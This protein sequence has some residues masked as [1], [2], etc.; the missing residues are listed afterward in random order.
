ME[1]LYVL[2]SQPSIDVNKGYA[3]TPLQLAV[4]EGCLEIVQLLLLH[5]TLYPNSISIAADCFRESFASMRHH[6]F[7]TEELKGLVLPPLDLALYH[8]NP[9]MFSLLVHDSRLRLTERLQ[10]Q[11]ER[12]PW[13]WDHVPFMEALA[14]LR[15]LEWEGWSWRWRR[16][17]I[18]WG[19]ITYVVLSLCNL[20]LWIFF[21]KDVLDNSL[22]RI[23]VVMYAVS[24]IVGIVG[25]LLQR[26]KTVHFLPQDASHHN[27]NN[28][29]TID[30]RVNV[31]H[32][33]A[34]YLCYSDDNPRSNVSKSLVFFTFAIP[35][36]LPVAE[37]IMF[38]YNSC[39]GQKRDIIEDDEER[40]EIMRKLIGRINTDWR[41]K[42]F[43]KGE[44][45]FPVGPQREVSLESSPVPTDMSSC[46][47]EPLP[48]APLT[49]ENIQQLKR[50]MQEQEELA[51]VS[52]LNNNTGGGDDRV[53]DTDDVNSLS[54]RIERSAIPYRTAHSTDS[55]NNKTG[56]SFHPSKRQE[57]SDEDGVRVSS[58]DA[59]RGRRLS[60][61]LLSNIRAFLAHPEADQYLD[62]VGEIT[63]ESFSRPLPA[64]GAAR[65]LRRLMD[66]VEEGDTVGMHI[67]A[68]RTALASH[69][70]RRCAST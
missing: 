14:V 39:V 68:V 40:L 62:E 63:N 29:R 28:T 53:S 19:S 51:A 45:E 47:D 33:L 9:S 23:F 4:K 58:P 61:P 42:K 25:Y 13:Q 64:V 44:Y 32:Y 43:Y 10:H 15:P 59:K 65:A 38:T 7:S 17:C 56:S 11:L 3:M 12:D 69:S 67:P 46:E 55:E 24:G 2:L 54:F 34:E 20:A 5:P 30:T 57:D 50:A 66:D 36:I 35:P 8:R 48:V 26:K 52:N 16:Q 31:F 6:T 70:R 21:S 60:S 37:C 41:R 22:T 49:A 18:L 1:M 27:G